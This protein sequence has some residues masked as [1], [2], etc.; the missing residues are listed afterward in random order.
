MVLKKNAANFL[1]GRINQSK[2]H[3]FL[4]RNKYNLSAVRALSVVETEFSLE[5]IDFI[6][7][8]PLC[9]M[10]YRARSFLNSGE[11]ENQKSH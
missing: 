9:I 11:I 6:I 5:I 8:R 1:F 10:L 2:H 7:D 3:F 4:F